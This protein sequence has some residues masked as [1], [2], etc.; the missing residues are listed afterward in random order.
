MKVMEGN[1][2]RLNEADALFIP[3]DI[4]GDISNYTEYKV[5]LFRTVPDNCN[6][7]TINN[8]TGKIVNRGGRGFKLTLP[9]ITKSI[10]VPTI[11]R[12]I[13]YPTGNYLTL[14][15][16]TASI[17]VAIGV[18]IENPVKYINSGKYQLEQLNVLTQSLLRMYVQSL[19]FASISKGS[20]RVDVFDEGKDFDKFRKKYG[21]KV[22]EIIFKE[23][24]LPQ[25]LQ[26][27]YDDVIEAKKKREKQ[28]VELNIRKDEALAR[29]EIADIDADIYLMKYEKL[30]RYLKSEGV[31]SEGI[32]DLIKT[33]MISDNANASFFMGDN[34]T[35]KSIAAGVAAGNGYTR[36]RKQ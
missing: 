33:Q 7:V 26:K 3:K 8:F 36:T 14:D 27:Q 21:I 29:K 30:I 31:P 28:L 20:C 22:T 10:L 2:V 5:G 17:D 23:V 12:V 6:L 34:D 16:I 1:N 15:H 35:A 9:W 11:D 25:E 13:D 4:D 24:K 18:R 32:A 19:D